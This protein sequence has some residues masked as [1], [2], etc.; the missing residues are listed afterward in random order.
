MDEKS[1]KNLTNHTEKCSKAQDKV[2]GASQLGLGDVGITGAGIDS[3][4]VSFF[5]SSS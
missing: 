3:L 4:E 1:N 2:K 5:W